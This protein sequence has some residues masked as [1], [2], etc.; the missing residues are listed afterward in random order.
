VC[1]ELLCLRLQTY[2]DN[3]KRRHCQSEK[4][5]RYRPFNTTTFVM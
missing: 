3:V 4:N 1:V 2:F 5:S